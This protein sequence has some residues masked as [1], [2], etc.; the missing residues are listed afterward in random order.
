MK[1]EQLEIKGAFL[2]HLEPFEDERGV[3]RRN[4]CEMEFDIVI[5]TKNNF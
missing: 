4:I 2:I 3:F 1:F 5:F